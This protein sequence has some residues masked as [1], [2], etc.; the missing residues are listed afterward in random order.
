MDLEDS[1]GIKLSIEEKNLDIIFHSHR[2]SLQ[3]IH[4][5][6]VPNNF[7]SVEDTHLIK[8]IKEYEM[9]YDIHNTD[10]VT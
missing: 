4:L 1:E 9:V 5:S 3:I 6:I 8:I 2:L 10:L 7:R